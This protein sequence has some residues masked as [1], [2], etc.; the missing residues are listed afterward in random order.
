MKR[1]KQHPANEKGAKITLGEF[2]GAVAELLQNLARLLDRTLASS[3]RLGHEHDL[4]LIALHVQ[5]LWT[6]YLVR[7]PHA[8]SRLERVG[9][10]SADFLQKARRQ[11]HVRRR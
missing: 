5:I 11:I 9:E 10:R 7:V 6:I 4:V 2:G 1:T 3:E 8:F